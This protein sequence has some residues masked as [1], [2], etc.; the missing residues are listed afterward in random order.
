MGPRLREFFR[1]VEAETF[2]NSRNKILISPEQVPRQ[3]SDGGA[4]VGV[5]DHGA[6]GTHPRPLS[7]L[8]PGHERHGAVAVVAPVVSGLV[9]APRDDLDVA[10]EAPLVV[11]PGRAG[12]GAG[13]SAA[14]EDREPE[15]RRVERHLSEGRALQEQLQ[16]T[17]R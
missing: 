11:D 1:P 6:Q 10:T 3:V 9:G 17:A 14:R 16:K 12:L 15:V 8:A 5:R 4:V 7:A 2:S 13:L